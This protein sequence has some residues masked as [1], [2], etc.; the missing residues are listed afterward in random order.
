MQNRVKSSVPLLRAIPFAEAAVYSPWP[1]RLLGLEEWQKPRRSYEEMIAEYNEGWYRSLLDEWTA[2]LSEAAPAQRTAALAAKFFYRVAK[3]VAQD[4][5]KNSAVYRSSQREYLF[6]VGDEFLAGDLTLG[7]MFHW[8]VIVRYVDRQRGDIRTIVEPGCGSGVNL[9][10]LYTRLDLETIVGGDICSNAV[11]LANGISGALGV[12]GRFQ[13]FDYADPASL[14][15]LT[16]GADD[17]ILLT[18]HSIEQVQ[19]AETHVVEQILAL[20][21]PPRLVIHCEPVVEAGERS[22]MGQLCLQYASRNRY[23]MDL[24]PSLVRCEQAGR[25]EIVDYQQRVFGFSAFN[26]TSLISWQPR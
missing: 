26:P 10:N 7:T 22:L 19:I 13:A 5:E 23:N 20:P 3:R 16:D 17:Y 14:R 21:N 24:L 11:A 25:L 15:S 12:P 9:F 4:V 1:D 2:F 6:S 18:C 8:D